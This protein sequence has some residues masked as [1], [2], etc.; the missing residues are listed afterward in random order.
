MP[1]WIYSHVIARY[2][3]WR[4]YNTAVIPA[5]RYRISSWP[6]GIM[7]SPPYRRW[8]KL[9][10][11]NN[12]IRCTILEI[13]NISIFLGKNNEIL[14]F[15][16]EFTCVILISNMTLLILSFATKL[17]AWFNIF[18]AFYVSQRN[19]LQSRKIIQLS[20]DEIFVK[21]EASSLSRAIIRQL[22]Q[23]EELNS[24]VIEKI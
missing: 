21:N 11:A 6:T 24:K 10:I 5:K 15:F 2:N 18:E 16:N 13:K 4:I 14:I 1:G 12:S 17:L 7:Q 23:N 9:F 8:N 20:L 3:L 22:L 19:E